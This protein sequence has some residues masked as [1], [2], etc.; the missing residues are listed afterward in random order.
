MSEY[1]PL[2]A[3][4]IK[5]NLDT[6]RVGREV[7]IYDSTTSTND[8]AAGCA[9]NKTKSDGLVIFAEHQTAG[10]GRR[11]N[12]WFDDGGKSI[13]CT[14][15]LYNPKIEADMITIAA[16]VGLTETIDKDARIKWPNDIILA[17]KKTAGVLV[18]TFGEKRK[19]YYAVGIGINCHQTKKDFP[20]ELA[21]TAT[22]I[23]IQSGVQCDRNSLA[24]RLIMNLDH[25]FESA[26]KRPDE[27]VEK[28]QSRSMLLHRRITVEH[29]SEDFTGNCIG[30]EPAEGLIIQL[31]RGGV[32]M[33]DAASTTI[34]KVW[35][36]G[37][38]NV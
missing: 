28:W 17:G 6:R 15:V 1:I 25:F 20:A 12:Q 23:D 35:T 16:A 21:K 38:N 31:E 2:D 36:D 4:F 32:R 5:T 34:V 27:I 3:D 22:S 18:E 11:G 30:I 7:I 14:V 33:F 37:G 29:N 13:L 19:K 26:V 8:I 24:K 9:Q 10:R